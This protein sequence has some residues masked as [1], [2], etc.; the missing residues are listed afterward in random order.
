MSSV[1]NKIKR[2]NRDRNP[3]FVQVKFKLLA[4]NAFRFFRG[5]CHL[6]Y[7]DLYKNIPWRD[8]TKCW[9]CGDLH[10]ENFGSYK[11]DNRVVYFDMNDFDESILA[12]ATW[13]I[14]R[15]VT[16]ICIGAK[17]LKLDKST[18]SVLCNTYLDAYIKTLLIGKP[19]VIEKETATGLLKE[20]LQNVK[21][22]KEHLF[23][24]ERTV[25]AGTSR[26]LKAIEGKVSFINVKEKK[27]LFNAVKNLFKYD[28]ILKKYKPIDIAYRI[29]GTGSVGLDRYVLLV[30]GRV[31]LSYHL[32]DIKESRLSSLKSY[33]PFKQPAWP[34][35]ADRIITLQRRIQHVSPALLHTVKLGK[36]YFVLKELQP[37]Q[38]RMD[39]ALCKGNLEKLQGI[40]TTMAGITA[41]AQLRATGRQSSSTADELIEFAKGAKKWKGKVQK[42]AEDYAVIVDAQYKEYFDTYT[43]SLIED[44]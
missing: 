27:L 1:F 30:Q 15:M 35:E 3:A 10:L 26:T 14:A 42:Y 36:K 32:L 25:K 8:K 31:S 12:P 13:E 38:D 37:T 21:R 2:F 17:L 34:N 4:E 29:A 5:T 41:S 18:T 22:R 23:I 9:I 7:E 6:F 16:S 39:L 19:Q 24:E 33:T 28:E 40:I 44:K 20:L 11:G 43:T